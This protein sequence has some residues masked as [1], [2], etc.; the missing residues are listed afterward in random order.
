MGRNNMAEERKDVAQE[1]QRNSGGNTGLPFG[2]CKKFNIALPDNA[3]PR[4]AWEVL[5]EKAGWTPDMV[6]KTLKSGGQVSASVVSSASENESGN[7]GKIETTAYGTKI[8]DANPFPWK[9]TVK[10]T[11]RPL[12][13]KEWFAAKAYRETGK[14][15][16][17]S[18][19]IFAIFG[20]T[21]KAYKVMLGSEY[22]HIV[23]WVPKSLVSAADSKGSQKNTFYCQ[24]YEEAKQ[25]AN[26]LYDG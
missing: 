20:E 2:L 8:K 3:T 25:I 7:A 23:T 1:E 12:E 21:E 11:E 4:D 15:K 6:Y 13:V 17:F 24:D 26:A 19:Q 10:V 16:I 9:Q 14:S 18:D 5:K 22:R